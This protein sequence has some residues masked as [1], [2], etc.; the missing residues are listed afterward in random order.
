M[1]VKGITR[2]WVGV[3][4]TALAACGG[5]HSAAPTP[6]VLEGNYT[7]TLTAAE[8]CRSLPPDALRRTYEA[9]LERDTVNPKDV[10]LAIPDPALSNTVGTLSGTAVTFRFFLVDQRPLERT[11][12]NLSGTGLGEIGGATISGPLAGVIS[13]QGA[14]GPLLSCTG[15]DH[16]FS[17]TRR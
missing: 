2:A 16:R 1:A 12:Y 10:V 5:G 17:L 3:S 9:H 6:G 7:L 4:L 13:Y 15:T 11:L 8:S 14:S